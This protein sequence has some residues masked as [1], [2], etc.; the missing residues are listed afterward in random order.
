MIRR[1][2]RTLEALLLLLLSTAA[3][4]LIPV[5]RL[6]GPADTTPVPAPAPAATSDTRDTAMAVRGA[7][8]SACARLPFKPTCLAQSLAASAM[9]RRRGTPNRL[10]I[11]ARQQQ[12]FEAHAWVE[13]AGL[14]VAGEGDVSS[15]SVMLSRER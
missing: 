8:R 1:K 5:R 15:Y 14:V 3:I 4:R 7:I 10:H 9:L 11:G 13:A 2:L 12:D 6:I